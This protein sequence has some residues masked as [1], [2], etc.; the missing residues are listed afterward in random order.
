MHRAGYRHPDSD[1]G[2]CEQRDD[3]SRQSRRVCLQGRDRRQR[4][5][6]DGDEEVDISDWSVVPLSDP[7]KQE[8]ILLTNLSPKSF[9]VLGPEDGWLNTI[10]DT[11]ILEDGSGAEVDRTPALFELQDCAWGRYPD[12]SADWLFMESSMGK[13]NSGK[14]CEEEEVDIQHIKFFHGQKGQRIGLCQH[15]QLNKCEIAIRLL[16]Y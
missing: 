3:D 5:D 10:E 1:S 2:V 4:L 16:S 9:Y 8:V 12:G 14:R 11:L 6:N 7:S 13:P 15:P